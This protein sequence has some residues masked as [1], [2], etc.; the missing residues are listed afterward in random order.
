MTRLK[1]LFS[2]LNLLFIYWIDHWPSLTNEI[3]QELIQAELPV[4]VAFNVKRDEN[5]R[6][7][8]DVKIVHSSTLRSLKLKSGD[9]LYVTPV[10]GERYWEIKSV[11]WQ[12]WNH[13]PPSA[14]YR[15]EGEASTHNLSITYNLSL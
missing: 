1:H 11:K 4:G 9:V 6:P 14:R 15:Q 12:P 8:D 7:G 5:G 3:L 10:W 2:E 13:V